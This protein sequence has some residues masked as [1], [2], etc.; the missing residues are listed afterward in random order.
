MQANLKKFEEIQG[1]CLENSC[2]A[3]KILKAF[4]YALKKVQAG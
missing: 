1:H 2:E 4:P 3:W